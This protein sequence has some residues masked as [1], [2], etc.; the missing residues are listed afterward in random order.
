MLFFYLVSN[1]II[2]LYLSL[3]SLFL[4]VVNNMELTDLEQSAEM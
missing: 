1:S 2:I 3:V 4:F